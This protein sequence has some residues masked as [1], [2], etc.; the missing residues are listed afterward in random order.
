MSQLRCLL[1]SLA[2]CLPS[3]STH[4][5]SSPTFR[6]ER[7]SIDGGAQRSDSAS[8]ALAGSIGQPDAGAPQ[9]GATSVLRG[10][11][12]ARPAASLPDELFRNGFE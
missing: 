10:G 9:V 8:L 11:F 4:G 2:V 5:Q 6:I 3:A 1:I 7:W 12:H